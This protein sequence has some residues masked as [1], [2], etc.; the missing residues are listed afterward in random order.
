VTTTEQHAAEPALA[1][2]VPHAGEAPVHMEHGV[3]FVDAARSIGPSIVSFS[4]PE[5]RVL[6]SG[7][8]FDSH[9][10]IL[11]NNH[12]LQG[13]D[14][15]R[16][17][18]QDG[19]EVVANLVGSD[20]KADLALV[21]VAPNAGE[22]RPATLG[23]SDRLQIGEWVLSVGSPPG[24]QISVSV[25][26]VSGI[27]RGSAGDLI[28]TDATINAINSGG[29]LVDRKGRVVGINTA[30]AAHGGAAHSGLGF[31]IPINTAKQ[32]AAELIAKA[33]HARGDIS[34]D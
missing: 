5:P 13:A 34:V 2:H 33:G 26:V 4:A 11:T 22:L 3:Q 16:V 6:G 27:G 30:P 17:R 14:S 9:G 8:V 7:V 19:R 21:R 29:P 24:S 12:V 15:A 31:A 10:H 28:H 23:D 25:G 32:V 18:F 1:A 20:P